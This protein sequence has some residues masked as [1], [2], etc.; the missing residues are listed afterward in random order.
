LG[1]GTIRREVEPGD[2]VRAGGAE[3]RVVALP[4]GAEELDG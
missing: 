2:V 3:A 4:F 1:L